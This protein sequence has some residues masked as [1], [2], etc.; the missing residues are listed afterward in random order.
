MRKRLYEVIEASKEGDKLSIV[1]DLIMICTIVFSILPLAFKETQPCFYYTDIITTAIFVVDYFLRWSTADYKLNNSSVSSFVRYPFTIWAIIDLISILPSISVIAGG[2]QLFKLLR[3]M[4][5]FK[6][7]RYSK[8]MMIISKVIKRSRNALL[9]VCTL[10]IGYIL[11]SALVIYNV[12]GDSFRTFF[13]AFYWATVSLTTVGYGDIYPVTPAGR[14]IT[15]IS[16]LFGIAIVAL[17][18]G[19]ITAGYMEALREERAREDEE[20]RDK[21]DARVLTKYNSGR[22]YKEASK[23]KLH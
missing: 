12:E 14:A 15:M 20:K 22:M 4:R 16:S 18:S 5:I 11:I 8:S 9:A 13:E 17:P 2:F 10:A 23:N 21:T 19:V 1:Y 3:I 7:F 6:A